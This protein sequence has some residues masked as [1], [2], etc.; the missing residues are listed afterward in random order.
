MAASAKADP[1]TT[2]IAVLALTVSV[3]ALVAVTIGH[4]PSPRLIWNASESVPLGLYRVQSL[5]RLFA[6]ELVVALPPEPL[7][8]FLANSGYLPKGVALI[9]HIL[10]LPQQIVCRRE[11]TIIVDAMEVGD[12]RERDRRGR[13][14]PSWQGCRT[15]QEGEVFLMNSDEPASLDGRYFGLLPTATIV[16]RAVPLWTFEEK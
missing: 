11:L 1:M 7:A 9:K 3:T 6:T 14:L 2:R 8:T 16:G 13:V 10:A 4:K 15:V 5:R 12:A